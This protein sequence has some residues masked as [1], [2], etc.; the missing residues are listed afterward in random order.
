M[1]YTVRLRHQWESYQWVE[2]EANDEDEAV[3]L[4]MADPAASH[5]ESGIDHVDF[6]YWD[7]YES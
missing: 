1:K 7:H 6:D 5:E 3:E 2:V 4:E